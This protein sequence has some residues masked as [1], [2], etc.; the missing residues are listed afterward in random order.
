MAEINFSSRCIV[1]PI[2]GRG[3]GF[4]CIAAFIFLK[5]VR[6]RMSPVFFGWAKLGEA[7]GESSSC[8]SFLKTCV[9]HIQLISFLNGAS[10]VFCAELYLPLNG[11]ASDKM[12]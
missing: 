9:S 3:K 2:H 4:L 7:Q 8:E 1:L 12:P 6:T 5:S 10:N 11:F